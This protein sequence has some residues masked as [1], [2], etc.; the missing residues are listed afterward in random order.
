MATYPQTSIWAYSGNN[1]DVNNI[2]LS[3]SVLEQSSSVHALEVIN[4]LP[5]SGKSQVTV[6]VKVWATINSTSYLKFTFSDGLDWYGIMQDF[7]YVS[8]DTVRVNCLIDYWLTMGGIDNIR[9]I[10]GLTTRHLCVDDTFGRYCMTDEL[11][12]PSEPLELVSGGSYFN[13]GTTGDNQIVV[14]STIDLYALGA[15]TYNTN[16]TFNSDGNGSCSVPIVPQLGQTWTNIFVTKPD[17]TKYGYTLP[18]VQYFDGSNTQ[19]QKGM[20]RAR[21]L[22]IESAILSQFILPKTLFT[23]TISSTSGVIMD[24]TSKYSTQTTT[25][26]YEYATVNNKRVLYGNHNQYVIAS[27]ASGNEGRFSPED[28]YT[29]GASAPTL[30]CMSDGRS[31]QSPFYRFTTLNKNTS[32]WYL[33]TVQGLAW[34]NAPIRYN[35]TSGD[36]LTNQI[37]DNKR[38]LENVEYNRAMGEKALESYVNAASGISAFDPGTWAGAGVKAAA[39]TAN[40]IYEGTVKY[41]DFQNQRANEKA[42]FDIN[43]NVVAPQIK[44]PRSNTIRDLVGNGVFVYRYKYTANDISKIDKLLTMYGYKDIKPTEISDFNNG[45]YF[46]YVEASNVKISVNIALQRRVIEGAGEQI[47]AGV[48]LWKVN[49]EDAYYSMNNRP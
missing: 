15:D 37:N 28:I 35:G 2:P 34:Q 18:C 24:I 46:N 42:Q 1:F 47:S 3:V 31:G 20:T 23:I 43:L 13:L 9:S 44:F 8:M 26:N 4:C 11:I 14:E 21:S 45:K 41:N 36:L 38:V 33:N 49:P 27:L 7:T 6:T 29:T 39:A 19:V 30:F 16:I 12:S 22:G 5:F 48:R 17:N 10:S 40:M 32:E 25:L